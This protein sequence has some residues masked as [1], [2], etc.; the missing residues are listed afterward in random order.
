MDSLHKWWFLFWI[1]VVG[2]VIAAYLGFL[3]KL[4]RVDVSYLGISIIILY[5]IVTGYVGNLTRKVARDS[6]DLDHIEVEAKPLW[7]ASE[8]MFNLGM[9]GTV[10]GFLVMLNGF[11]ANINP[12]DVEAARKMISQA[13]LGLSTSAI[14]TV[15][16]LVCSLFSKLQLTNLEKSIDEA[17]FSEV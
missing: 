16:G 5:F 17:R 3:S 2:V 9:I 15:V 12:G 11:N 10:V 6:V 13:V 4:I 1:S 7:F 14:T 8:A